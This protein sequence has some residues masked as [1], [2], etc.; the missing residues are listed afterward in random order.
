MLDFGIYGWGLLFG[1]VVVVVFEILFPSAGLLSLLA[2]SLLVCGG[3][4]AARTGGSA[5]LLGYTGM[6]LLLVP[7]AVVFAFR[8]LPRTPIG[9]RMILKG[10][11]FVERTATEEGLAALVGRVG[12]SV[13]PLRPAGI[14]S[15]DARRVDVVTRGTHLPP[16][17]PVR[18]VKVEGNRVIVEA[19]GEARPTA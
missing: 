12:E 16:G 7:A 4:F 5:A 3:W 15:I 2:C 1:G 17:A 9:R 6:A 8:I 18:V 13:T 10:P 11:S 19:A 14:A